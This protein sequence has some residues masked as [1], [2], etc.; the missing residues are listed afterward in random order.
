MKQK[1]IQWSEALKLRE[2]TLSRLIVKS[3]ENDE[4]RMAFLADPKKMLEKELGQK[5][6]D[7]LQIQVLEETGNKV[8]FT[9]PPK[10]QPA[11]AT[12]A[13][14]DEALQP[15]TGGLGFLV[16]PS[17]VT[18]DKDG[19]LTSYTGPIYIFWL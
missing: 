4:F 2:A 18:K 16:K 1:G 15:V 3:W 13:L 6:P 14:S 10:P 11:T 7:D 19:N 8:Y 12:G 9:I 17:E 5:I